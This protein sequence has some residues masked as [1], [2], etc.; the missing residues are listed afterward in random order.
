MYNRLLKDY[1][2]GAFDK[3]LNGY[4]PISNSL[5]RFLLDFKNGILSVDELEVYNV[6]YWGRNGRK[7]SIN[8]DK[9]RKN[10]LNYGIDQICDGTIWLN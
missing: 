10:H 7:Y 2:K 6:I 3:L 9:L 4:I 1:E 8:L 5:G